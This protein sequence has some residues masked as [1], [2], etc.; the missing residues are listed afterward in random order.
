MA[1]EKHT[2]NSDGIATSMGS[3]NTTNIGQ[4][5]AFLDFGDIMSKK[6]NGSQAQ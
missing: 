2:Q 1:G 4:Y 5:S 3:N 6:N